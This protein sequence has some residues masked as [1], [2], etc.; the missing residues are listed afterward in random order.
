MGFVVFVTCHCSED[1][2]ET[3]NGKYNRYDW[4]VL[5]FFFFLSFSCCSSLI[6]GK[7][8]ESQVPDLRNLCH[9]K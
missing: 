8:V 6:I 3:R 7:I 5:F 1:V 2:D 9:T 4:N